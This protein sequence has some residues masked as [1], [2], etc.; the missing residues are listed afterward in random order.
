MYITAEPAGS[1]ITDPVVAP[2]SSLCPV[3]TMVTGGS[4]GHS[5][6]HGSSYCKSLS[7]HHGHTWWPI[8]WASMRP[9]V[10]TQNISIITAPGCCR[11]MD[12]W[13]AGLPHQLVRGGTPGWLINVLQLPVPDGSWQAHDFSCSLFPWGHTCPQNALMS[14][15]NNMLLHRQRSR[16]RKLRS[17]LNLFIEL[18]HC[19]HF[20]QVL[21]KT[22]IY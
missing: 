1:R 19:F 14:Y 15:Q 18:M 9:F 22:V 7:C 11:T 6:Y 17:Y 20:Y 5:D 13:Q 21:L 16:I 8:T 3:D 10:E 2:A 4:A 12:S